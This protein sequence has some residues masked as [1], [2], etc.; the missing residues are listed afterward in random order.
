MVY[1]VLLPIDSLYALA[2]CPSHLHGDNDSSRDYLD[3][4]AHL[5]FS[6]HPDGPSCT[7]YS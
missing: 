3:K 4:Q 1:C 2:L 6:G 7:V 5:T